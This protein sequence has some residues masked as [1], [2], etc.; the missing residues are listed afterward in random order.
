M[1]LTNWLKAAMNLTDE[2]IATSNPMKNTEVVFT[3]LKKVLE[4]YAATLDRKKDDDKQ[5]YV[6]TKHIQKDRK[7]L[8]FGAVQVKKS[9]VSI[10]L[11]PV[12]FNPELLESISGSLRERMQGKSCFNFKD[13]D[14]SLFTEL[15]A[16]VEAGYAKY[17]EQGY[18]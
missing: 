1:G 8:F 18:V 12:Y 3:E 7:P 17:K 5:L 9:Y 13:V 15:A 16:L 14:E 6:D 10:H 11:M 4:P 2:W